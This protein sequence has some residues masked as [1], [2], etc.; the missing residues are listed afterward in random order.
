MALVDLLAVAAF[1]LPLFGV[2]LRYPRLFRL[3]R[4]LRLAR[5]A[6]YSQSLQLIG[7]VVVKRRGELLGTIGVMTMLLAALRRPRTVNR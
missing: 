2:D 7:R 3:F 4:M 6:R 1:Y 5:L